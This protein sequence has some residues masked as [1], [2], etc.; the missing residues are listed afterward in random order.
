MNV[1][2]TPP[3]PRLTNSSAPDLRLVSSQPVN[4]LHLIVITLALTL[5]VA[6]GGGGSS[7]AAAVS[8]T[9]PPTNMPD[10]PDPVAMPSY[11][12]TDLDMARM[13]VGGTAPT[14]SM[15]EMEIV[16]EIQNRATA[17][18][19]FEFS[20][21]AP[22][23]NTVNVTCD[24][25]N[26]SC[27]T[28]NIP[29]VGMLTFSLADIED[30]SLVDDTGLMNF[31]S[32]TQVVMIDGEVTIIQ[33]HAE[34]GQDGGTQL[35]FQT[36]GGWLADSAFGVELMNVTEDGT[37]T[38]RFASFS[39][40]DAS[41]SNP[42][43]LD[44]NSGELLQWRGTMVGTDTETGH[45]LHGDVSISYVNTNKNVLSEIRFSGVK[46]LNSGN[47]VTFGSG[48]SND[49]LSFQDVPVANGSFASA[50]GE[51]KGSFYGMNH[52]EAGG[53]LNSGTHNVIGAFGAKK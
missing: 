39:F 15:T 26:K 5:L 25:N 10:M 31:D 38:N 23:A 35:T 28:G 6:C 42:V 43:F 51:V 44:R 48:N 11:A 37:T 18:D 9:T 33:S 16:T 21:F 27:V 47:D 3:P 50:N 24:N 52:E 22:T 17:A 8:P 20:N 32:E 41:G 46:N 7:G 34:A 14:S 53:I 29:D 45:V 19:T 2:I 30:L 40:G 4:F 13:A 36:Y 49:M 1:N 12:V